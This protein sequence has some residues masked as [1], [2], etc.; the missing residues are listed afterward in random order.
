MLLPTNERTRCERDTRSYW[1][2]I[3]GIQDHKACLLLRPEFPAGSS[4]KQIFVSETPL[5]FNYSHLYL[6]L[7][8]FRDETL[9]LIVSIFSPGLWQTLLVPSACVLNPAY[10]RKSISLQV[11]FCSAP[12]NFKKKKRSLGRNKLIS[13]FPKYHYH[14]HPKKRYKNTSQW[15]KLEK[16]YSYT[17]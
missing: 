14:H 13:C 3:T 15:L 4:K 2:A 16:L 9:Y 7:T 17:K 5:V 1:S 8:F 10:S 12:Y 11:S 6:L